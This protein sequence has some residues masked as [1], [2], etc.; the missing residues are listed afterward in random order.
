MY[1]GNDLPK[2]TTKQ[3]RA[4]NDDDLL[5]MLAKADQEESD[6]LNFLMCTGAREKEA[7]YACWSDLDLARATYTVTE[8]LDLGFRPKDKEEASIPIPDTLVEILTAR[9]KRY[10]KSRLPSQPAPASR[11][12][13]SCGQSRP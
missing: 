1:T 13:T 7:Q 11:T 5:K 4:Y 8:H 2:Y 10:P 12:A 6:L 9:R 3:V